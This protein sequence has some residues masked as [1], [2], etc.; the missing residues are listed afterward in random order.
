[1]GRDWGFSGRPRWWNLNVF[2]PGSWHRAS[3]TLGISWVKECLG[4]AN[5]VNCGGSLHSF[6]M[7]IGHQRDQ[8]HDQK[9]GTLDKLTLW[10]REGAGDWVQSCGQWLNQLCLC[11]QMP[12]KTLFTEAQWSFLANEHTDVLGR[13]GA[14]FY[15]GRARRLWLPPRPSPVWTLCNKLQL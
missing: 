7:D 9:V 10:G 11:N 5:E 2:V 4:N 14:W 15:R 6:T 1:M 3:K 12:I 13:G 8:T